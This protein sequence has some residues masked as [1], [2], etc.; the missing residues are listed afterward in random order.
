MKE[1]G[2]L[3]EYIDLVLFPGIHDVLNLNYLKGYN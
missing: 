3:I 2:K 1:V